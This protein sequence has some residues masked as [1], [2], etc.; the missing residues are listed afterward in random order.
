MNLTSLPGVILDGKYRIDQQLGQGGM[1]AVF[2]ATHLGTTRTVALK[3]IVPQ[4]AAQD[5]FLLRFQRE[6]EAAGRLRHPNVVNVTDFGFTDID[7]GHLAYLVM[8]F[9]D[10]ETLSGFLKTNPRPALE[11]ILDIVDQVALGLDAAHEAG[12]VHRDLK[13]DNIWLESNRR[14]GHNVKVLDFGIAKLNNPAAVTSAPIAFRAPAFSVETIASSPQSLETETQVMSEATEAD[15]IATAPNLGSQS[16]NSRLGHT[17]ATTLQTTVGSVM[18]TPAFMAPEQCQGATVDHRADIYSLA[19]IAYQ[20]FCGRLPFEGKNLK[21]LLEQQIKATP[22]SPRKL[23]GSIAQGVSEA[24]LVGLA[25]DPEA[26][27]ASAGTL[28]AQIRAGAAGETNFLASGKIF[29]TNNLN[30]FF[31]LLLSSFVAFILAEVVGLLVGSALF[32]A[33]LVPAAVLLIGYHL[34]SFSAQAFF[35]Q[36][37]KAACSMMFEDAAKAGYFRPRLGFILAR[38]GK[39]I[40]PLLGMAA[41]S[42][43]SFRRRSFL[44]GALW[45]S[46]WA[47]EGLTGRAALNRAGQLGASQ[48]AATL[49]LVARQYGI[50][51]MAGLAGPTLVI[52]LFGGFQEYASFLFS[53]KPFTW[54]L[55]FYPIGLSMM[56][57]SFGPAFDFLYMS[58][59][60]CLGEIVERRLPSDRRSKR[61]G[62]A[63]SVRPGTILWMIPATLLIANLVYQL[64]PKKASEVDLMDAASDGRRNSVLRAL[65]SGSPINSKDGRDRTALHFAAMQGDADLVEKL[66]AHGASIDVHQANGST[67]LIAAVLN[68]RLDV[69]KVLL[70]HHANINAV[71]NEGRTAL[72]FAAMQ[73]DVAICRLLLEVGADR[74]HRDYGGKTALDYAKAEGYTEQIALLS[75]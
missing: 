33:K 16:G 38:L 4:L 20:L 10:G 40:G 69:A 2:V 56:F 62:K 42:A 9:L 5:E 74:S 11:L 49:A 6:A 75:K 39:A 28:A 71:D 15:T 1:G 55:V 60:R 61:S 19:T 70:Q 30:C 67:P 51:L 52:T 63:P 46:V 65:D 3:V 8:E 43:F 53:F 7:G 66:L 41:R 14:G 45:P 25:K 32:N 29:S 23:D 50:V 72:I 36:L 48:P 12:I 68:H 26:R 34:F 59:R 47:S 58:T 17:S 24:I 54:V 31:P 22:P 35:S 21:D 57:L 73:G 64:R 44:E 37:Y 13:P 27:P 18:G